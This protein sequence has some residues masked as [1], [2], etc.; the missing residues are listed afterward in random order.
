MYFKLQSFSAKW[1]YSTQLMVCSHARAS[2]WFGLTSFSN[3]RPTKASQGE[4][5]K[6][7]SP[8]V[9]WYGPVSVTIVKHQL[10]QTSLA[11][12]PH[13]SVPCG[14]YR[15]CHDARNSSPGLLYCIVVLTVL[16]VCTYVTPT[17]DK[18]YRAFSDVVS[19]D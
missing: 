4:S 7:V 14:W 17:G 2:T 19:P 9:V 16:Q 6:N 12:K 3:L 10:H 13:Q 18:I 15:P 11:Y 5:L 1:K 8:I